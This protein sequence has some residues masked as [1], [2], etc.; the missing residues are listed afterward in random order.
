MESLKSGHG[1]PSVESNWSSRTN[2][3]R[4]TYIS[5]GK[6]FLEHPPF[7]LLTSIK[8][9]DKNKK[10]RV[11]PLL[12]HPSQS[13]ENQTSTCHKEKLNYKRSGHYWMCLFQMSV[14][15]F[16][17]IRIECSSEKIWNRNWQKLNVTTD[18][19][20]HS[21]KYFRCVCFL[22]SAPNAAKQ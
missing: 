2:S 6:N 1:L 12:M 9:K 15:F 5:K 10:R 17:W 4:E 14:G 7:Q 16:S 18:V 20:N 22:K 8:R 3:S 19:L 13:V 21:A 11:C